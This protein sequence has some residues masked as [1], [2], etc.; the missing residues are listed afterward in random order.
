LSAYLSGLVWVTIP[1]R[2]RPH[3]NQFFFFKNEELVT[4]YYYEWALL[5]QSDSFD[6]I[7]AILDEL[8]PMNLNLGT[9]YLPFDQMKARVT[10]PIT[11][12]KL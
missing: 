2:K 5:R 7:C 3:P 8:K 1:H 11:L 10:R 6:T 9:K 12:F 4:T